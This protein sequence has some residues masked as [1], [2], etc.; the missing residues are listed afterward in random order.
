MSLGIVRWRYLVRTK[1]KGKPSLQ[2]ALYLE[3]KVEKEEEVRT[4][5]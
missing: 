1:C 3:T 2:I 4:W 5:S